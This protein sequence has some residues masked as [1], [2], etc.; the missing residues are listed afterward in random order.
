MWLAAFA[1]A[2]PFALRENDC[3]LVRSIRDED[4]YLAIIAVDVEFVIDNQPNV[5]VCGPD[6]V[7]CVRNDPFRIFRA[8]FRLIDF[9]QGWIAMNSFGLERRW[10]LYGHTILPVAEAV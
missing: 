2:S 5:A 9:F 1:S 6:N 4:R 7:A 10:V 8:D 3:F